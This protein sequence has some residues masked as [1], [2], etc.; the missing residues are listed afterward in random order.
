L[1]L[2]NESGQILF[3]DT[4]NA[5]GYASDYFGY[6]FAE[7]GFGFIMPS[8]VNKL[9]TRIVALP[10]SAD[11]GE[12]FAIDDIMIRPTGPQ[13]KI[14]FDNEPSTTIVKSVC[15]QHNKTISI[16]GSMGA[17]YSNPSLQWQQSTDAGI[18]WTD[19]AGDTSN[20]YTNVY[21][22]PDTFLFRLSGA[23]SAN[24]SNPNCR[25]FSNV[26]KVGVDDIPK[27]YIITN[28]SP[29]CSGQD[30]KFNAEG[31]ASYIWAGPN[32]FYDN[33]SYP[34]IYFSSL[35]DSGMYYVDIFS[36]GGCIA[37]DSTYATVIGTDVDAGPDTIICK[38]SSVRLYCTKAVSY[39]WSPAKGFPG[40]TVINPVVIPDATTVY[41]VK[42]TDSFGCSDT[43]NVK[44]K[45]LNAVEVKAAISGTEYLC[46][47]LDSAFFV[48]KSLGKIVNWQWNFNNG[49]T[50]A[51][52]Q[53]PPQ[54]Y[55]IAGN[56][57]DY[58]IQLAVRDTAGCTDTAYHFVHVADNCYIAV[59]SAFTPNNDGLND[60]LYPLNAYKA[61]NLIFR[62]YNRMGMLVFETRD[63]TKKWDGRLRGQLQQTGVYIWMLDYKDP[64]GKQVSQKGTTLLIR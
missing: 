43:A 17:F 58:V 29:V 18:T 16:T 34:H 40:A 12:D 3:T 47:P 57:N 32:G 56:S 46:R 59:P 6:R 63:W 37:K 5:I 48:D 61:T 64:S 2:E 10:S 54:Y 28:N 9:V 14:A 26:L 52:V 7:Y 60:W 19:I 44:V 49:N 31:G 38:G 23:E 21:S 35:A 22:T 42:V 45:V 27:N 33:I 53:P 50:S 24:I 62:I 25:V 15:F 51:S 4:T 30:L 41:T 13:I 1:I 11:C 20:N 55:S 8:G 36:P 39:E